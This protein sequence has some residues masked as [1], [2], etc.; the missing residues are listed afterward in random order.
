MWSRHTCKY[1]LG[2]STL[3]LPPPSLERYPQIS[4]TA[5]PPDTV[6]VSE[7]KNY[8]V[9]ERK[10]RIHIA[11]FPGPCNSVNR[12]SGA[13]QPYQIPSS[14]SSPSLALQFHIFIILQHASLSPLSKNS[15]TRALII[16][17]GTQDPLYGGHNPKSLLACPHAHSIRN[18]CLD[19]R[20]CGWARGRTAKN[21]TIGHILED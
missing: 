18:G 19:A 21:K 15:S 17:T 1:P 9:V 6:V 14:A 20:W 12:S 11:N 13:E 4:L 16:L 8:S 3:G 5:N 2:V 7:V 10:G